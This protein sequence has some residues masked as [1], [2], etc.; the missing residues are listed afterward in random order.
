[1]SALKKQ[2]LLGTLILIGLLAFPLGSSRGQPGT[3]VDCTKP[4]NQLI[5]IGSNGQIADGCDPARVSKKNGH[6]IVWESANGDT[7]NIVFPPK[8]G[9]P[10]P[11]RDLSCSG[12]LCRSGRINPGLNIPPGSVVYFPYTV[13]VTPKE[14]KPKTSDPGA[15]IEP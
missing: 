3:T 7:I 11:F 14:G 10:P 6:R 15:E 4:K 12:D 1:M 2:T 13:T 8:A 9:Y 5:T